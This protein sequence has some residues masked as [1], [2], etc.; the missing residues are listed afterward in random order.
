M[1]LANLLIPILEILFVEEDRGFGISIMSY[2][3]LVTALGIGGLIYRKWVPAVCILMVALPMLIN[4]F[5]YQVIP[6]WLITNLVGILPAAGWFVIAWWLK[7]GNQPV[8][9]LEF[10]EVT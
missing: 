7:K 9:S 1:W 10:V 4:R 3:Y 5:A 8:A 6:D 2:F